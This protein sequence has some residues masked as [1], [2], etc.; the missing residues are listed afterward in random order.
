[1]TSSTLN[2]TVGPRARSLAVAAFMAG[3]FILAVAL[4]KWLKHRRKEETAPWPE[5]DLGNPAV[6]ERIRV[7]V[8]HYQITCSCDIRDGRVLPAEHLHFVALQ[9]HFS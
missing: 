1:M 6:R 9:N 5:M 8:D 4:G 2:F 3:S 7:L